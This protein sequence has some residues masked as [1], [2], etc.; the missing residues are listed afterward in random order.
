MTYH[1]NWTS[2]QVTATNGKTYLINANMPLTFFLQSLDDDPTDRLST[3]YTDAP[4]CVSVFSV[5]HAH[6]WVLIESL[7]TENT[8]LR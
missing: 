8:L 7:L 5:K 6:F 4:I 1:C 3:V 2:I